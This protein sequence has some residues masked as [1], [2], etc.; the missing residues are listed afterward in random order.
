MKS[1][2]RPFQRGLVSEHLRWPIWP[3]EP[4][5]VTIGC[6]YDVAQKTRQQLLADWVG[7]ASIGIG[8]DDPSRFRSD[9]T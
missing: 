4:S 3:E 2:A 9:R 1:S 8:I 5:G 7:P 6:G